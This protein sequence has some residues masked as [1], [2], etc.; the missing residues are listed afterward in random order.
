MGMT[1]ST[2]RTDLSFLEGGGVMGD[3]IRQHDWS[4]TVLGEPA[5]WPASL[6]AALMLLLNTGHPMCIFWGAERIWFYN[7]PYSHSLGPERHPLS[8]GR[9]G[10]VVWAET[11]TGLTATAPFTLQA[12]RRASAV[13]WSS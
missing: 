11:C 5:R 2:G 12:P 10:H 6:R 1:R 9:H 8:L 13:W 4:C 3:R 7:D